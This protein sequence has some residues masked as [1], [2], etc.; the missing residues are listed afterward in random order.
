MDDDLFLRFWESYS[1]TRFTSENPLHVL[2]KDT[3]NSRCRFRPLRLNGPLLSG[4]WLAGSGHLLELLTVVAF[5]AFRKG[6]VVESGSKGLTIGNDVLDEV[7]EGGTAGDVGTVFWDDE[8]GE[9]GD[10]ISLW[11]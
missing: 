4:N 1:A 8:E 10:G 7:S 3:A 6:S 5:N 2:I 11:R 9:S